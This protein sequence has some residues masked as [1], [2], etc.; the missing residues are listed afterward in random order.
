MLVG[1]VLFGAGL[2][3]VAAV[4]VFYAVAGSAP[5]WLAL[6]ALLAPIG[7]ATCLIGLVRS[8]RQQR[9]AV[10]DR[11]AGSQLSASSPR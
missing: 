4:V 3:G 2:L 1:M 6:T 7:F 11:L 10:A 5:L 9:R 8:L